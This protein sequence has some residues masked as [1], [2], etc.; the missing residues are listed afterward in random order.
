VLVNG[1]LKT[2]DMACRDDAGFY[3]I[4]D[5]KK[6]LIITSGFNVYPGEVEEVLNS[7]PDVADAAIVGRPDPKRGEVVVAL[8]VLNKGVKFNPSN[9]EQ[10]CREHLAAHK[11]PRVF[12]EVE[13]ALP[14][15]FLGK[16]LRRHLRDS[17]ET[18]PTDETNEEVL[19]PEVTN[20]F[21]GM[22]PAESQEER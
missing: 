13:G 4:V 16:V 22:E 15:N 7:H 12:E 17:I 9:L 19:D 11:R 20:Q 3:K 1:W 10:Y 18:V 6:D 21:S 14:R 5:R 2:G 8:V